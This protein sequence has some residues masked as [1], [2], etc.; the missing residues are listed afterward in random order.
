MTVKELIEKLRTMN[1][2]S[3]VFI[4]HMKDAFGHS[5]IALDD[6]DEEN[7]IV[8]NNHTII[9]NISKNEER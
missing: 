1:P 6:F 5:W 9:I 8:K 2:D 3:L 7:V 4:Q